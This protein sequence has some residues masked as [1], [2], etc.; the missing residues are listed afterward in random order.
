MIYLASPYSG[1]DL[2]QY[3]RYKALWEF[4]LSHL[5]RGVPLFSPIVYGRAFESDM[6]S[7]AADWLTFNDAM[8]ERA[9]SLWVLQ[10][11]GWDQSVGVLAEIEK[12]RAWNSTEI[13][14]V[15]PL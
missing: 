9:R 12:F 2:E 11:P 13:R 3:R 7:T 5:K 8:L 10:L 6:G 15:D 1:T 14:F 4:T